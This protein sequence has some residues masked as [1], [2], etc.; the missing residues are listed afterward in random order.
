MSKKIEALIIS[1][2]GVRVGLVG[3]DACGQLACVCVIQSRHKPD[4]KFR[5]SA[6][7]A[8]GIQCEHGSDVCPVCDPCTCGAEVATADFGDPACT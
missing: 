7:C 3:C 5:I 8:V 1:R 2:N 4:C 6:T